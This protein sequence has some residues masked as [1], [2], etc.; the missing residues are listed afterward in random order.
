LVF[1]NCCYL[2]ARDEGQLLAAADSSARNY[3]RAQFASG[4]AEE[5]INLGVRCVIAAGWAVEDGPAQIFATTFYSALLRGRRFIDTVSEARAE[6]R[7]FGGN[8]W[9]AYQCYGDPDWVFRRAGADAQAP[10]RPVADEFAGLGSPQDLR[11]ALDTV[12]VQSRFQ[13]APADEQQFKLRYLEAKFADLWGRFGGVAE[14]F[15]MAWQAAGDSQAAMSWLERAVNANDGGASLK[16][17]EQLA[18]VRVREA[19]SALTEA[20]KRPE[21]ARPATARAKRKARRK[22]AAKLEAADKAPRSS[23][24]TARAKI[25]NAIELLG[26]V[27][28]VGATSERESLMASAYKR[29]A[30][31]ERL[32]EDEKAE[33]EAIAMMH[34]HYGNAE[35]LASKA[36]G[37]EFFYPAMNRLAAELVMN[38]GRKDWRG[39]DADDV[40]RLRAHI[41]ELIRQEP[42]FW[43]VVA[44]TELRLYEAIAARRLARERAA[45]EAEYA[46]LHARVS[47]TWMWR[48]VHDQA[49]FVLPKYAARASQEDRE[50]ATALLD[51]LAGPAQ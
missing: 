22:S 6:A 25:V 11:L 19:W 47:A 23:I 42:D 8:T 29:L 27:M 28:A 30:L 18:N 36:P 48:S 10:S 37:Q 13:K 41:E 51:Y 3:N 2:A 34:R 9:G 24:D 39:L 5:L 14:A 38:T 43:N 33:R 49:E 31:I 16:A 1:V 50:A 12:S 32:A 44:R 45:I 17:A 35:D 15:G 26:D 4:V 20:R 21:E 7:A 46:D 40:A